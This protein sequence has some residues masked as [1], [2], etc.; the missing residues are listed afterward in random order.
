MSAYQG[1]Q[2]AA[3]AEFKDRGSRFIACT[4]EVFDKDQVAALLSKLKD[5]HPKSRHVCYAYVLSDAENDYRANDDGE[6]SGSA[7]LPILNQIK[8]AGVKYTL[9]AVVRYFGG[10]KL[11]V[12]GLINAYKTAAK[13]ALSL[14]GCETKAEMAEMKITFSYDKMEVVM[15]F[16]K[17]NNAEVKTQQYHE[18]CTLVIKIR[19]DDYAVF[20]SH[21]K[22]YQIAILT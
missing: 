4:F 6:P 11:G 15:G 12:P 14:S 18:L 21:F 17:Q 7:G 3:S 19:K 20:K 5:E 22:A 1:I 13:E 16:I 10:T 2:Q 9:V 8:S